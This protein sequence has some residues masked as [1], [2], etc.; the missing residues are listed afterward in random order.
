MASAL[1]VAPSRR[2]SACICGQDREG[3]EADTR[4]GRYSVSCGRRFHWGDSARSGLRVDAKPNRKTDPTGQITPR[5]AGVQAP[6]V[7]AVHKQIKLDPL[8]GRFTG[9]PL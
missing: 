4:C 3:P 2:L 9:L 5:F 1:G 8:F 7:L 6:F